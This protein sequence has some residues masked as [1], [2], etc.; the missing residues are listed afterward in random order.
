MTCHLWEGISA[1]SATSGTSTMLRT[2]DPLVKTWRIFE[3]KSHSLVV[4]MVTNSLTVAAWFFWGPKINTSCRRWKDKSLRFFKMTFAQDVWAIIER[5]QQ[6]IHG[7]ASSY[8]MSNVI[9][10]NAISIIQSSNLITHSH[11]PKCLVLSRFM[12]WRVKKAHNSAP[13]PKKTP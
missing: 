6:Q 7:N 3:S 2:W 10:Y 8:N 13:S 5:S 11:T 4:K 1:T 12:I 9:V